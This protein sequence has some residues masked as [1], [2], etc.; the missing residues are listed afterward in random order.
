MAGTCHGR[1]AALV[2]PKLI[3]MDAEEIM[4]QLRAAQAAIQRIEGR[5][6]SDDGLVS[7]RVGLGGELKGLEL[8]PRIYR[9]QD[10]QAL[11][12]AI[13][14]TAGRAM[15]DAERLGFKA[16]KPFLAEGAELETTDLAFDPMLTQLAK[17]SGR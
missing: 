2:R 13:V 4:G 1:G 7:V 14:E 12:S 3:T 5:A 6:E 8:D 9:T 16:M 15:R 17:T 10:A 11:A